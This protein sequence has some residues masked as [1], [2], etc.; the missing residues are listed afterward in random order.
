M[1]EMGSFKYEAEWAVF[2]VQIQ[3]PRTLMSGIEITMKKLENDFFC[4]TSQVAPSLST[5]VTFYLRFERSFDGYLWKLT[6]QSQVK[7][8]LL[9]FLDSHSKL[10]FQVKQAIFMLIKPVCLA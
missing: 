1:N 4:Q 10:F 6:Y 7:V 8:F 9:L 3:K 2:A 5:G